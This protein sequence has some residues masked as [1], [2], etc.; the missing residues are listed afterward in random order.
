MDVDSQLRF[1][2]PQRRRRLTIPNDMK[3]DPDAIA[4]LALG[5][6]PG[7]SIAAFSTKQ[8]AENVAKV[9]K[10]NYQALLHPVVNRRYTA[11]HLVRLES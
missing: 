9:A 3:G 6:R 4:T 10:K 8:E 11:Y 7:D 2:E 5:L 1:L